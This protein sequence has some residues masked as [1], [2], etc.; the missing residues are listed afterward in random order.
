MPAPCGPNGAPP[1]FQ[2]PLP[3]KGSAFLPSSVNL[4]VFKSFS[5][6][7]TFNSF[8]FHYSSGCRSRYY[9]I[10]LLSA[11]KPSNNNNRIIIV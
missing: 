11:V 9:P 4:N 10:V 5:K 3:C 8:H 7:F 1:A 6:C 2:R